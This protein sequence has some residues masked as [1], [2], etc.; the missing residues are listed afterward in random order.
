MWGNLQFLSL[1]YLESFSK[2]Q[3][4]NVKILR[5]FY[6]SFG[7]QSF[8]DGNLESKDVKGENC[9]KNTH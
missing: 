7:G 3:N 9:Y 1:S 4:E 2:K 8:N 6:Q 5:A